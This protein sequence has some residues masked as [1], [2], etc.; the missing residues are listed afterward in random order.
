MRLE[1]ELASSADREFGEE[2]PT[3]LVYEDG[4]LWVETNDDR[5]PCR[6][7]FRSSFLG[8]SPTASAK[9]YAI[10]SRTTSSGRAD[11]YGPCLE[12]ADPE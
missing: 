10:V 1:R 7:N 12:E 8:R 3:L 6:P 4:K 9:C 11:G 2:D 5:V